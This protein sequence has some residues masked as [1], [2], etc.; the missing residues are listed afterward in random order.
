M[1]RPSATK[2]G[3]GPTTG[4]RMYLGGMPD[5]AVKIHGK[6]YDAGNPWDLAWCRPL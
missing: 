6:S 4:G 2:G 3:A 1:C 5:L